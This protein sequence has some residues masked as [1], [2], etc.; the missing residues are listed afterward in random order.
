MLAGSFATVAAIALRRWNPFAP[1]VL[2]ATSA[3]LVLFIA[4]VGEPAAEALKPIPPIARAIEAQRKPGAVVA[5]RGVAG[6][7]ALIFYTEP[8]VL[9]LDEDEAGFA[10]A[11]CKVPDLYVVTRAADV[12]DLT[13]LASARGRNVIELGRLRGVTALHVTGPGCR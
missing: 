11:I 3:A 13:Q 12:P 5:A 1:Y 7:Y 8:G 4:F 6:T 2:G 9:S 10:A